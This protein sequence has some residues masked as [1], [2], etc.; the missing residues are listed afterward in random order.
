MC[1]VVSGSKCK[2]LDIHATT[3]IRVQKAF[4]AKTQI[5]FA[6]DSTPRGFKGIFGVFGRSGR[7]PKKG[8][9]KK[10]L[11]NDSLQRLFPPPK[12]HTSIAATRAR[13]FPKLR[14]LF[15]WFGALCRIPNCEQTPARSVLP[16]SAAGSRGSCDSLECSRSPR[17]DS[18]QMT[19][20]RQHA[21]K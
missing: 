14:A 17:K 7:C 21:S 10:Q 1:R 13:G 18:L 15:F 12:T 8:C 16:K 2:P 11:N 9:N 5:F 6:V 19:R 4:F 3:E 20:C